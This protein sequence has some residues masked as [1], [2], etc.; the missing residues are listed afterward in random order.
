MKKSK[1]DLIKLSHY[2][3]KTATLIVTHNKKC[4]LH[5]KN[6]EER[7]L[8]KGSTVNFKFVIFQTLIFNIFY[9]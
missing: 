2:Q 4:N 7:R 3:M 5:L 6:K 9:L 1:E 8:D